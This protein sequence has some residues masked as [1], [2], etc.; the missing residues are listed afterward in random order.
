MKHT[1]ISLRSAPLFYR[2][3]FTYFNKCT[4]P[5]LN[6]EFSSFI[7]VILQIRNASRLSHSPIPVFSHLL[8][9][10]FELHFCGLLN[11]SFLKRCHWVC[12]CM[13]PPLEV[14]IQAS[15]LLYSRF[16][17]LRDFHTTQSLYLAFRWGSYPSFISV[18]LQL[19]HSS[20]VVYP[21]PCML[22]SLEGNPSS[23]TFEELQ[24]H[25]GS[26]PV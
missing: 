13:L 17:L 19:H 6:G 7:P 1:I 11:S 14:N 4:L 15:F 16:V 9:E 24:I 26:A 12:L 8:R 10:I 2:M 23:F 3:R 5:F 18:Y 22:P 20:A 21:N 25:H